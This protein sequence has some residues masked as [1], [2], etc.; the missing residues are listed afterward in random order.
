MV[1]GRPKASDSRFTAHSKVSKSVGVRRRGGK[2]GKKV[3]LE[4]EEEVGKAVL[5]LL[6]LLPPFFPFNGGVEKRVVLLLLLGR[7][8]LPTPPV[9]LPPSMDPVEK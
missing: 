4:G 3:P 6:L 2:V 7:A 1:R 8:L 9:I 5:L